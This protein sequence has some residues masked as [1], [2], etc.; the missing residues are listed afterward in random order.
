M[1]HH[2]APALGNTSALLLGK[3]GS[4]VLVMAPHSSTL[5]WKIPWMEEPGRLQ[6]MGLLRVGHDWATSLSLF[7]FMLWRRKCN[8]LQCSCLENPR[9]GEPGGLLSMGSHRVGHDWSDLAALPYCWWISWDEINVC[10]ISW[11]S[12]IHY[13][14]GLQKQVHQVVLMNGLC[15][16]S[17]HKCFSGIK[18]QLRLILPM[19]CGKALGVCC[20]GL[21]R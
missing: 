1:T 8:P 7:T 4:P 14:N 17:E 18:C 16:Q 12:T 15:C 21:A 10:L 19:F 11:S 5:A 2:P 6:S 3:A 13:L 9:D 20:G